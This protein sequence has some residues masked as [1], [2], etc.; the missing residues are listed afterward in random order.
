MMNAA[1]TIDG[2]AMR[3][4]V[5]GRLDSQSAPELEREINAKLDGIISLTLDFSNLL[6][7][8]SAGL[9]VILACQK[10]MN[11][12]QGEMT[13]LNPNELVMDVFEATGF[14]DIL[15]IRQGA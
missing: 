9:R 12:V 1:V 15:N 2:N 7:I 13:V 4:K 14:S 11:A 8:S 3:I 10:K 5:D 6:Y